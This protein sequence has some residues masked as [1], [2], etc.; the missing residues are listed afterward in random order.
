LG[1]L[2]QACNSGYLGGGD[3]DDYVSRPAPAKEFV[4]PHLKEKEL[5][6]VVYTCHLSYVRKR[7]I[8]G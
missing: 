4:R 3:W 7:K 6:M 1:A 5:G 2:A 8:E